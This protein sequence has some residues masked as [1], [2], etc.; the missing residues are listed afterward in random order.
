MITVGGLRHVGL[1]FVR[2]NVVGIINTVI[3]F[4]IIFLFMWV[5]LGTMLS[6]AV[7]YAIGA[8]VSY[9]LNKKYTFKLG[10]GNVSQALK[11]FIILFLSYLLNLLVLDLTLKVVSPYPAQLISAVVYTVSS[12]ILTKFFVFGL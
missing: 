10:R 4:S 5:G 7:G 11:F 2:Y 1:Q 12:F 6:N 3:G 9:N 8:I